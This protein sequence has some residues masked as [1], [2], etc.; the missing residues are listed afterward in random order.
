MYVCSRIQ[1]QCRIIL[2]PAVRIFKMSICTT[3]GLLL[4][5]NFQYN[6][7]LEICGKNM[8]QNKF[9]TTDLR[10]LILHHF[11]RIMSRIIF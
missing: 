8:I 9:K 5:A 4:L 1:V 3:E 7:S 10:K 11:G 2:A 6:F